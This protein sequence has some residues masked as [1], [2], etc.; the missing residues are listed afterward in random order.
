MTSRIFIGL[1]EDCIFIR[2][3]VFVE[4]QG[5]SDEF[6]ETDNEAFHLLI[7]KDEA[8][9]ATARMFWNDNRTALIVGRVAVL[10]E[11]REH[12][13]GS[14]IMELLERKAIE[15]SCEKIELSAQLRVQGFYEKQGYKASGEQ[16]YDQHCPHIHMEKIIIRRS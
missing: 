11:E 8:P 4:E 16:Y 13:V 12:N 6:D 9:I 7:Y 3:K 5:F 1:N 15:E 2:Q 10:E 14:M